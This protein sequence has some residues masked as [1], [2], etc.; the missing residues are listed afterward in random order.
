MTKRLPLLLCLVLL[1]GCGGDSNPTPS[2]TPVPT[3]SP[4]PAPAPPPIVGVLTGTVR[5]FAGGTIAGATVRVLDGPSA[6]TT[7]TTNAS[8]AY[9]FE[10][11]ATGDMN[12]QARAQFYDDAGGGTFVNGANTL[13]FT[14]TAPV[15]TTRGTGANVFTLPPFATRIRVDASYGGFC[16]NFVVQVSGRLVVNEILGTCSSGS[17][18]TFTGTY[19]VTPG[20]VA[21]TFST[22]IAWTVTEV[23]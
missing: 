5:S 3:P 14:L 9:R 15:F 13:N 22:G 4:T 7:V 10:G 6:G 18:R 16:E 8:G 11:I 19:A 1:A 17:G 12:F 21:V 23:R 20:Q 2:P